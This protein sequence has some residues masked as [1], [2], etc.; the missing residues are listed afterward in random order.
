MLTNSLGRATIQVSAG[1]DTQTTHNTERMKDMATHTVTAL[2]V[3][4]ETVY[5][6]AVGLND[7]YSL[8]QEIKTETAIKTIIKIVLQ[9]ASGYTIHTADGGYIMQDSGELVREQSVIVELMYVSQGSVVAIANDIKTA[10]N[11]ESVLYQEY[12]TAS[13]YI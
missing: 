9:H 6:L 7:R 3:T 13:A 5:R 11:Q 8:R 4:Q 10:L 12:V 1:Q 2:T